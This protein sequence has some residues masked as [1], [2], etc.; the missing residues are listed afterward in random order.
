MMKICPNISDFSRV[1]ASIRQGLRTRP[2]IIED[3]NAG[4][5]RPMKSPV[6]PVQLNKG[7]FVGIL[8]QA[9]RTGG[10]SLQFV[11]H[12][13]S[14]TTAIADTKW[15]HYALAQQIFPQFGIDPKTTSSFVGGKLDI[16]LEDDGWIGLS[17]A[18]SSVHFSSNKNVGLVYSR[19]ADLAT[20][21]KFESII[22]RDGQENP[23]LIKIH[24]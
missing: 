3:I 12:D 13:P 5:F 18:P 21:C 20:K 6:S 8:D 1:F 17:A 22:L 7:V 24:A 2:A 11:S 9:K 10:L 4:A 19:L 16:K 23:I 15:G 14:G